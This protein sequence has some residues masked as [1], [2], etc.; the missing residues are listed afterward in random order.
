MNDIRVL[1]I[2]PGP[3]HS[4]YDVYTNY[5]DA[6]DSAD[7]IDLIKFP[8]H[9]ILDWHKSAQVVLTPDINQERMDMI[10][11]SRASREMLGDIAYYNPDMVFVIAGTAYPFDLYK[12]LKELQ[13]RLNK[14]FALGIYFTESPYLDDLQELYVPLMDFVYT[15]EKTSVKRFDPEGNKFVTYLPHSYNESV[16]NTKVDYDNVDFYKREVFF[17]GTPFY[18]RGEILSGVDWG[19]IDLALSGLWGDHASEEHYKALERYI[20]HDNILPND[21]VSR[22]YRHSRCSINIHRTRGDINGEGDQL[23]NH[24]LYSTGPR[25]FEVVAS[26]GF[27]ITDYRKEIVDI[28]GDSVLYFDN[29]QELQDKVE[30]VLNM[31]DDVYHNMKEEAQSRVKDCTFE[32]RVKDIIIPDFKEIVKMR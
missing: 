25:T 5:A 16:H 22:F 3:R 11:I 7:E 18:E 15:N 29:A 1:L 26:G 31:S 4:T 17:C 2:A 12:K 28:F 13:H 14:P 32:R 21:E 10:A 6:F 27:L 24:K 23:D 19:D 8:Y 30:K 9:N 20:F